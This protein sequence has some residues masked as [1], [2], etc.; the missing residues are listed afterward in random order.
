MRDHGAV[1]PDG[2]RGVRVDIDN[3]EEL[4][5]TSSAHARGELDDAEFLDRREQLLARDEG[6]VAGAGD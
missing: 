4:V 5:E 3:A 1:Q 6:D 2:S